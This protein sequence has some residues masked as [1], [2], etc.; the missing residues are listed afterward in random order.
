MLDYD[1]EA[2]GYDESRGGEARAAAAAEAI[3][4]LLPS[5]RAL[6]IVDVAGGTGIVAAALAS[7]GRRVVVA[8]LSSGMLSHAAR[9]LPGLEVRATALSLPFRT[10]SVDV[11]TCIWLLHLL[12][13]REAADAVL[14]EAARILRPGGRFVTTVDKGADRAAEGR[15][16]TDRR[17]DVAAA[18]ATY[19]LRAVGEAAFVGHGQGRGG[20]DPVY[21]L[22]AFSKGYR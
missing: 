2:D 18:A 21:T 19:S 10:A 12:G 4:S 22:L 20:P 9:R 13:S 5:S 14:A 17:D 1:A 7:G 11:V 15:E 8:D 6:T 3:G 16:A